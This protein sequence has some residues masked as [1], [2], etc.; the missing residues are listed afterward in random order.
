MIRIIVDIARP[1]AGGYE[2]Q[3]LSFDQRKDLEKSFLFSLVEGKA[4]NP[5]M[6]PHRRIA[7]DITMTSKVLAAF[8]MSRISEDQSMK[9][10]RGCEIGPNQRCDICHLLF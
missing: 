9:K 5:L 6:I 3:S 2:E 10:P 4:V 1:G 7:G 8:G